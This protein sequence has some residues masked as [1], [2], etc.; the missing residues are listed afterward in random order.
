MIPLTRTN[1]IL[2][3]SPLWNY[4]NNTLYWIDIERHSLYLYTDHSQEQVLELDRM[5]TSIG[6]IDSSKLLMATDSS[7]GVFDL[8]QNKYFDLI[9]VNDMT[10]KNTRL[11][12]G[13]SDYSGNYWVSS[14]D[15]HNQHRGALF[16]LQHH[17]FVP[18]LGD[19]GIGN[20]LAFTSDKKNMYFSDSS[21]G[22]STKYNLISHTLANPQIIYQS[23]DKNITPDGACL[24]SNNNYWCALWG[25]SCVLNIQNQQ[26]ISIPTQN[27]TCPCFG[28]HYMDHLFVTSAN[29]HIYYKKMDIIGLRETPVDIWHLM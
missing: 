4:F 17:E 20:G 27:P 24:D 18:I 6:L 2:G 3:E 26:V 10:I 28:G 11:N 12:D 1:L 13:K 19:I 22:T 9:Q 21:Y 7:C 25:G 14:K 29:S 8:R 5:P 16:I 15:L 23:Q